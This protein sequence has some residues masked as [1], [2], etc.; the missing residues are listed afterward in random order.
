MGLDNKDTN[1]QKLPDNFNFELNRIQPKKLNFPMVVNILVY[2]E[3]IRK[4]F[5]AGF[6]SKFEKYNIDMND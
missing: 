2:K 1:F 3:W 4:I 6:V 5:G